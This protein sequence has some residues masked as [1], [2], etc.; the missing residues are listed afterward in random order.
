MDIACGTGNYTA[1]LAGQS[2]QWHGVDSSATMLRQALGKTQTVQWFLA[3]AAG[4][5]FGD[6]HFAGVTCVLAIHHF[7]SLEPI[8]RE[9]HRVLDQGRFVIFTAGPEQLRGYWLNH[10]F[11]QA[12][13]KSIQQMPDLDLVRSA[14][15]S[16]GFS[17]T[18]AET[19]SVRPDLEDLFLYSGKHKP[20]MYLSQEVRSGISTFANLAEPV[21]VARGCK[22]LAQDIRSGRIAQV[23]AQ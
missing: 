18:D 15:T 5:P 4:L 23:V 12:M 1:A 13:S 2:G 20:K 7:P 22:R 16:A 21:E 14:L 11:P 8:F 3:D 10:Y 17:R 19:Y 6:G 9:V